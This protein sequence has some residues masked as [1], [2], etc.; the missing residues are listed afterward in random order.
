MMVG[1]REGSMTGGVRTRVL[2]IFERHRATPG[3][4]YEESH[5]IDFLL[6]DPQKEGAVANSFPGLQRFN[7]F[8]DEVQIELGICFSLADREANYPLDKFVARAI[9]LQRSRRGSL[10]SLENQIRAGAGWGPLIV[11]NFLLL[12][13]GVSVRHMAWA[14]AA[15]IALAAI[16]NVSFFIFA[17]REQAKL[18]KLRRRIQSARSSDEAGEGGGCRDGAS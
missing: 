1:V 10:R 13:I 9:K 12:V 18:I 15:I 4:P 11:A 2:E 17:R 5:F 16:T 14:L 8:L 3:T 6:A 7:A